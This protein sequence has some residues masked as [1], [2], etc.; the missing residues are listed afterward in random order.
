[1]P[2]M[3]VWRPCD[4]VE[5]AVA[6][7]AAVERASGPT[8][9][10]L[11]RQ[12]LPHQPRSARTLGLVQR[13]GYVLR[14]CAGQPEAVLLATGSEVALA[15]EAAAMLEA[16]GHTV[17]VVS[18]PCLEVFDSQPQ[19]Y[20]AAVLPPAAP[21]VVAV[22]AGAT[23]GWYKYVGCQGTV[24]GLDRFGESAPA[25]ALFDHFGLTAGRVAEA[26]RQLIRDRKARRE[27]GGRSST[28]AHNQGGH[29]A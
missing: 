6:W 15:V 27:P 18:M 1:M 20:R 16:E 11:S 7:R 22:E 19:R 13:G 9:L 14:D 4:A 12:N 5:T 28:G 17:R 3:H 24:I 26:T 29:G 23:A 2:D 21:V 8:A 25:E 10:I